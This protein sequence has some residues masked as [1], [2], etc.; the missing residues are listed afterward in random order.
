M[1]SIETK[2]FNK[3]VTRVISRLNVGL[4]KSENENGLRKMIFRALCNIFIGSY[5]SYRVSR[6]IDRDRT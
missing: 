2:R 1:L 6:L 3:V 4:L 5:F